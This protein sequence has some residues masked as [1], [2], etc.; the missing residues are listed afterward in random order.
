MPRTD[1]EHIIRAAGSIANAD[2]IVIIGSQALLG[3]FRDPPADLTVSSEADTYP[4]DIPENADLIDGSIGEKSPFLETFGLCRRGFRLHTDSH[5]RIHLTERALCG[6]EQFVHILCYTGS[7]CPSELSASQNCLRR[8]SVRYIC[9][10]HN[11]PSSQYNDDAPPS[12]PS[13]RMMTICHH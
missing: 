6:C 5:G 3:S 9:R 7:G 10:L 12:S 8:F 13:G 11:L 2:R 1:L 4:L